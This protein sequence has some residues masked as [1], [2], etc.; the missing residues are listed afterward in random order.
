MEEENTFLRHKVN[1]FENNL[2]IGVSQLSDMNAEFDQLKASYDEGKVR[3]AQLRRRLKS[4]RK[5]EEL[6]L[7]KLVEKKAH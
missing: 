1:E 5:L 4:Q 6:A 7:G 2:K 3:L